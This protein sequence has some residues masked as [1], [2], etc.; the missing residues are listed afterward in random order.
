MIERAAPTNSFNLLD[1][2]RI[3]CH[4]RWMIGGLVVASVLITGV[5]S[6]LSPKLYE[7][8][9][10]I[11]PVK[12]DTMGGGGFSFGGGGGKEKG[13]GGGGGSMMALDALSG[14]SGPTIM[15]T[16]QV[17][18]HSR[19]MAEAVIDELNLML[20]Y[21]TKS[22]SAA[23]GALQSEVS[24]KS[25]AWKGLEITVLSKDPEMA[26][27][28]ANTYFSVLDRLN[29]EYSITAT[30][31][32][33]MFVEARLH[34]K[35]QKLIEAEEAM[36][37]FQ[38]ENRIVDPSEQMIGAVTAAADLHAQIVGLEVELAALRAYA[39]PSHPQISQLEAQITELRHQLDR[40]D[41]DQSGLLKP[42]K[43]KQQ[44]IAQKVF[45]A[46]EDAP[47]LAV[48]F[49]RLA[50]RQ[51]VEEAVYGMLVGMLESAK[52]AEV[53]DLPTVQIM[54]KALPPE[55]P[56]RPQTLRNVQVAAGLSL[57]L[58]V[59]LAVF[60]DH[61]KRIRLEESDGVPAETAIEGATLVVSEGNGNSGVMPHVSPQ[62]IKR[63][64]S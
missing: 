43:K 16:L 4:A 24:V 17:L 29:K 61:L 7:A 55:F 54:D 48:D 18:L 13:G 11:L 63:L 45:P 10:T 15:D 1:Y 14:K 21:E 2:W 58:G 12:E 59:L 25:N 28:I 30:K 9:A 31:R 60:L 20:Y 57:V 53:R 35:A 47:S 27:N 8:K 36:M 39:L 41:R 19:A 3:I 37:A 44:S 38:K 34:E 42:R 23:V 40:H 22:R 46:F 26:A 6:K 32:N 62:Q 33:R 5:V 56:S 49:L 52:I 64:H 50:R 51:K